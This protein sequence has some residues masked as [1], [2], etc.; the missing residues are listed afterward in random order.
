V[1][2]LE[3]SFIYLYVAIWSFTLWNIRHWTATFILWG[4]ISFTVFS[5]QENSYTEWIKLCACF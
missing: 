2:I 4:D 5:F 3:T 1:Y